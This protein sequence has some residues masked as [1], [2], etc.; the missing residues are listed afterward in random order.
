MQF[1]PNKVGRCVERTKNIVGSTF[2]PS[3]RQKGIIVLCAD[4]P[5]V[6]AI[7]ASPGSRAEGK[8]LW[9]PHFGYS[10][11][12]KHATRGRFGPIGGGQPRIA[13]SHLPRKSRQPSPD[14][15]AIAMYAPPIAFP[16]HAE[17]RDNNKGVPETILFD[18]TR[19][20]H[21]HYTLIKPLHHWRI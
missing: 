5:H 17:R 9:G 3:F 4:W 2:A 19:A 10:E 12:N 16:T 21:G 13:Q 18:R 11:C 15:S 14:W 20:R 6:R 7:T 1:I 8:G